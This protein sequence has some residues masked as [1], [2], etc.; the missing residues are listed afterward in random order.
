MNLIYKDKNQVSNIEYNSSGQKAG[1]LEFDGEVGFVTFP[2]LRQYPYIR[3]GFSTRMGG[4]SKE[5]LSTMNL[6]FSRGDEEENVRENYRRICKA[7]KI[8][9]NDMVFSDQVHD[10]KIHVVTEEDRGRGY[11]FPRELKGIDGLITECTN[12]PLVTYYADCVPL[13]FVDT[14]RKVIGL[15]HSGWKGTVNKMAIH[16]IQAMT[17]EFGTNPKDV[18]AVI[19]PSICRD[20][21]E[22]SE[23]VASAFAKAYQKEIAESMLEAKA[24]GKN[25]LD[26]WLAN[27]ENCLEAGIPRENITNSNL[28]TCCNHEIFFSHRASNGKRGNLAAFLSLVK[29]ES[30]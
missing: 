15:S 21:Y 12:I 19:G 30:M 28:C 14:K 24:N 8:N 3:H 22:V 27:I 17:K 13:Y 7:I 23:D 20:C 18:V 11:Q 29:E 1:E 6:S 26:L 5:H 4:V 9:P 16:T 10:T 25:Q 2:V